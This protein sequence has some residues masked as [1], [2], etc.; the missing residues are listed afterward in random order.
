M[1]LLAPRVLLGQ[2]DSAATVGFVNMAAPPMMPTDR[3]VSELS[4]ILPAGLTGGTL[5]QLRIAGVADLITV[6]FPPGGRAGQPHTFCLTSP[7]RQSVLQIP[8]APVTAPVTAPAAPKR[9][10]GYSKIKLAELQ[11]ELHDK[12]ITDL[13]KGKVLL[14]GCLKRLDSALASSGED[15]VRKEVAVI[16]RERAA[17]AAAAR[18]AGGQSGGSDNAAPSA[19][20]HSATA[21]QLTAS[22]S[23]PRRTSKKKRPLEAPGKAVHMYRYASST[24][25]DGA[26]SFLQVLMAPPSLQ[27]D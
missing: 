8:A 20:G 14:L 12:G 9:S 15:G 25:S 24:L 13:P 17:A 1:S 21:P 10:G 2:P 4:V 19:P 26:D 7:I 18:S 3:L 23:K 6:P 5:F 27:A 11:R 16:N 22:T